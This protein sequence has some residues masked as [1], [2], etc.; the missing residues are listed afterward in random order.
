VWLSLGNGGFALVGNWDHYQ[1]LKGD[2]THLIPGDFDGDGRTDLLRQE[3][4][5]ADDDNR[6]TGEV[7]LSQW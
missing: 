7:W 1:A 4:W 5:T 2:Y 6:R 3:Y